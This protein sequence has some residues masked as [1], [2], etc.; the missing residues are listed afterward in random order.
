MHSFLMLPMQRITRLPLLIDAIFHRLEHGGPH[1]HQC[2]LALATLNKVQTN[3]ATHSQM[4]EQTMLLRYFF[5]LKSKVIF[6]IFYGFTYDFLRNLDLS[7]L[8]KHFLGHCLKSNLD[9]FFENYS[10][11]WNPVYGLTE[12]A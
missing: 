8:M 9:F 10:R 6:L 1:W 3:S 12:T 11:R 5:L 7:I 4:E 2:N